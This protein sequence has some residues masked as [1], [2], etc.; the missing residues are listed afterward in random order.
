MS[1]SPAPVIVL[2]AKDLMSKALQV[3]VSRVRLG[4]A[5]FLFFLVAVF[6]ANSFRCMVQARDSGVD[7]NFII[8]FVVF[9]KGVL[10]NVDTRNGSK[11]V[12]ECFAQ[13]REGAVKLT[14][15]EVRSGFF[16]LGRTVFQGH[17]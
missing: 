11:K 16:V 12:Y 4:R 15:W 6:V 10:R 2:S 8:G 1:K 17:F 13:M 7:G 9:E 3:C 14:G 5:F